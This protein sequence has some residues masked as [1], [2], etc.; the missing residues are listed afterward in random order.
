MRLS[1]LLKTAMAC[2]AAVSSIAMAH[3]TIHPLLIGSYTSGRSEGIYLY[4]FDSHSGKISAQ[5]RQI[6]KTDNPSWL[7]FSANHRY[8][9]AVNENGPGQRDA[10]GRVSAYQIDPRSGRLTPIN[11]VRSLGSEPTHSGVSNDGRYLFVANYSVRPDPG[12]TLTVIPLAS[13]GSLGQVVQIKTH[14]ASGVNQERQASPHVHSVVSAPDGHYVFV[15]DLG[16]DKIYNYRYDPLNQAEAPLAANPNQPYLELPPGSGPRHLLFGPDAKHA[17]LTLEMAGKVAS[18]DYQAT[19]GTLKLKQLLPLTEDT[20]S[21]KNSAAA[22]HM[23]A[24]GRFLYVTNRGSDNSILVF[25]VAPDSGELTLIERYSTHGTEPREFAIDPSGRF[26]LIANQHSHAIIV[27]HR[28]PKNGKLGGKVQQLD[29]DSPS[30]LKFV[31]SALSSAPTAP[32][33]QRSRR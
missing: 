4:D 28:N 30:D 31:P 24:D 3:D 12:G 6:V 32:S 25:S 18:L 22:L 19:T 7:T 14:Q 2:T 8:L 17:Y 23:S 13:D 20:A 21:S 10:I 16:A 27:L 33:T 26:V 9:Y 5:P 1:F 15:Q 11:Q 29:I